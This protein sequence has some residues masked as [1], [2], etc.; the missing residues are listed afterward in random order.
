MSKIKPNKQRLRLWYAALM[1]NKY[2]QTEGALRTNE[3][4]CCLGVACDVYHKETGK[5][6]W[7]KSE[8][9]HKFSGED[10]HLPEKVREWFGIDKD[11][12]LE[13]SRDD[14]RIEGLDHTNAS[15]LNDDYG[16]SFKKIAKAVK[17][18]YKL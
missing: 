4:F 18:T 13:M 6:N 14:K 12:T 7:D 5:G 8:G 17:R 16:M 15:N 10:G 9:M 1:S 3:G 11:P 2:D